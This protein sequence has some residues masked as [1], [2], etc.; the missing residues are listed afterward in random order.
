MNRRRKSEVAALRNLD[1]HAVHVERQP[2]T[3]TT[4]DCGAFIAR[5]K[6]PSE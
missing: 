4:I 6:L 3:V 5:S 1:P 2:G